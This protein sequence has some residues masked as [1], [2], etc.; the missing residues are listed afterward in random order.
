MMRKVT[1]VTVVMKARK[2][3]PGLEGGS[4]TGMQGTAAAVNRARLGRGKESEVAF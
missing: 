1:L 2:S 3:K 4:S